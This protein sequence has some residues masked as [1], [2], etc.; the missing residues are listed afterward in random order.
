VAREWLLALA[1][2]AC[3]LA[4]Y[5][6]SLLPTVG[7][8]DAPRYTAFVHHFHLGVA[9]IEHPLFVLAA[10]P[11]SWLP[12][13]SLALRV[14]LACACFGAT[15]VALSCLLILRASGSRYGAVVGA[16]AFAT[17]YDLWWLATETEVYTLEVA[18]LFAA[19]LFLVGR[20]AGRSPAPGRAAF[21]IGL[22]TLNHQAALLV[23]PPLL[24][25]AAGAVPAGERRRTLLRVAACFAAGLL[26][27]AALFAAHALSEGWTATARA[28]GGGEFQSSFFAP[29]GVR[30]Y[31][32]VVAFLV[33][34]TGY[35]FY[36][37][38][39]AAWI[40]G[41]RHVARRDPRRVRLLTGI[42]G[43]NL[44]AV[45]AYDVPDRIYFYL[46]SFAILALFLGEGLAA[47]STATRR[48]P[49]WR[50]LAC[51]SFMALP[52]CGKIVHYRLADD[53][54]RRF[55]G[56]EARLFAEI[57][58]RA[59]A[60]YPIILP[61]IPTRDDLAYYT[62]PD[63]SAVRAAEHYRRAL[64]ALP[65][66][67]LVVDDWYHGYA[68]MADYFQGVE[69]VRP[70]VEVV[71][72]FQRWGGSAAERDALARRLLAEIA[73]GREIFLASSQYPSSTLAER[74]VAAGHRLEPW[75]EV[76]DLRRVIP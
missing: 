4:L 44:L 41:W 15:A 63:K 26:P 16:L 56:G 66:G 34:I 22:A 76:E 52:V 20:P 75:A 43:L 31:A 21:V 17:S 50:R 48:W 36:P 68:I 2:G 11:F 47:L 14:N 70:D 38:H 57:E 10:K 40:G 24:L 64:H 8:I 37:F 18:L 30:G 1:V 74:I 46:P 39:T 7:F 12:V 13:G 53:F 72:W 67:A 28:A 45:L 60:D 42:A 62:N 33:V 6:A 55:M 73:A 35:Q 32:R 51:L 58:A 29:I 49:P 54:V 69:G 61:R 3:A 9:S 19:L 23:L 27:Y 59:S 71:R 5:A 25:F 65:A